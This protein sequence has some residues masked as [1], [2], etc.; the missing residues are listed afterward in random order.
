MDTCSLTVIPGER[1]Q[2]F[3]RGKGTQ[4][5]EQFEFD[6]CHGGSCFCY[7]ARAEELLEQRPE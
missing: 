7:I 2:L 1:E 3:A 6:K 5:V 4:V